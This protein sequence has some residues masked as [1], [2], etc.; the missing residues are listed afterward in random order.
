MAGKLVNLTVH[1]IG[2][3]V[4]PLDPG[5]GETWVR[6]DQF[7]RVL[8]AVAGR[9]E[10]RLTF[11]DGNSSDVEIALP[12]LVERGLRAEFF[13]LAGRLGTPG[14]VDEAGIGK[15][16]AAGMKI[17]SHGWAHRDWRRLERDQVGEELVRAPQALAAHVGTPVHRV[18]IPF[19]S[20]D[21][22]VLRRLRR[23]GVQRAYT[24]DGGPARERDWL[25]PRTSLTRDL[26]AAW[27]ADVLDGSPGVRRKARRA[28]AKVV[29][30]C[31]G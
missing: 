24:S 20:Y 14:S 9:P 25:Q 27:I 1:G 13:L 2:T 21:R 18:A 10:V 5:E 12:R 23:A 6:V 28:V 7:E 15:L 3:P 4:R 30:R 26:D 17:G 22:T 16:L 11:D 19:G 8:D 29:K 31:R